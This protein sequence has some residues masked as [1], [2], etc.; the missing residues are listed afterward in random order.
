MPARVKMME[1]SSLNSQQFL[2]HPVAPPD[3]VSWKLQCTRVQE[4][5]D[6]VK[7]LKTL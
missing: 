6:F 2:F 3:V 4:S 7:L 5:L 1:K